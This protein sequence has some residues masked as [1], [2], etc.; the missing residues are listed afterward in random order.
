MPE[1]LGSTGGNPILAMNAT[2]GALTCVRGSA[3]SD[4]QLHEDDAEAG[5]THV[6]AKKCREL[7]RNPAMRA[8]DR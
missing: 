7:R 3:E 1:S 2:S 6:L 4:A 8:P 5:L